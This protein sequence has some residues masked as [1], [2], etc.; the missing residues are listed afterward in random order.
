MMH[1]V[2]LAEVSPK[3]AVKIYHDELSKK[4]ILSDREL[5]EDIEITEEILKN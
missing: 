1:K 3:E 2:I 5:S 4:G